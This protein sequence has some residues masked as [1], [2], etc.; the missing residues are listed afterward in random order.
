MSLLSSYYYPYRSTLY[1]YRYAYSPYVDYLDTS[2]AL[3]RS[4][5][6]SDIA[7]ENALRRSRI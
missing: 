6:A 5:L 2:L 4:R 7:V 1:P 3:R